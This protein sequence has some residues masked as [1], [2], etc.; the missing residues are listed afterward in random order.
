MKKQLLNLGKGLTKA[1]Q[2]NICGGN[3]QGPGGIDNGGLKGRGSLCVRNGK[4]PRYS[5]MSGLTCIGT[6]TLGV[7]G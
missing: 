4:D 6:G 1:A 5:C 2:K 3:E 7:C